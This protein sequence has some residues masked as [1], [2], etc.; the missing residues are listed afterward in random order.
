[1]KTDRIPRAWLVAA[2]IAALT[3]TVATQERDRARIPDEHKWNLADLYP[4]E[5]AWRAAKDKLGAEIPQ[6]KQFEGRL[7]SS[8]STLADALDREYALDKALSRLDV[9]AS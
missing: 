4:N 6:I 2:A 7:V 9:Y 3:V 5:A 1:M 8:A